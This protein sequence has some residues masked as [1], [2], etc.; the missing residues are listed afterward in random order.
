M[1]TAPRPVLTNQVKPA[2]PPA[3]TAKLWNNEPGVSVEVVVAVCGEQ[4]GH[5]TDGWR[6]AFRQSGCE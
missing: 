5:R 6:G 2:P 1:T 3:P 4:P